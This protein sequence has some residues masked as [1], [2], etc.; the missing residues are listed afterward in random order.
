MLERIKTKKELNSRQEQLN[1]VNREYCER[2]IEKK[3]I[4]NDIKSLHKEKGKLQEELGILKDM[5]STQDKID[6][7]KEEITFLEERRQSLLQEGAI[8]YNIKDILFAIYIP[9]NTSNYCLGAFI[10]KDIVN[11]RDSFTSEMRDYLSYQSIIGNH[12]IALNSKTKE[13]NNKTDETGYDL[14]VKDIILLEDLLLQINSDIMYTQE[15]THNELLQILQY[16]NDKFEEA[17]KFSL[18]ISKIK[19][20]QKYTTNRLTL[21]RISK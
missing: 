8:K 11:I 14:D 10:Y 21:K 13:V 20:E 16:L 6:S 1:E 17:H 9:K 18:I 12:F 4:E 3:R 2:T 19:I 15:I 7:L 5:K